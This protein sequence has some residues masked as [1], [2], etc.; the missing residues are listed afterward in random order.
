MRHRGEQSIV[1]GQRDDR[2]AFGGKGARNLGIACQA[3]VGVEVVRCLGI[4]GYGEAITLDRQDRCLLP[5]RDDGRIASHHLGPLAHQEI[6]PMG[7]TRRQF[8]LQAWSGR[9]SPCQRL[10]RRQPGG[11]IGAGRQQGHNRCDPKAM[12]SPPAP[13]EPT[14]RALP[15]KVAG[16]LFDL[17]GTLVDTEHLHYASTL[18]VLRTWNLSLSE[19]DFQPFIGFAE[20][21]YWEALRK[22]FDLPLTATAL[23]DLRTEAYVGLLHATSIDPL[24]GV[25]D[26]LH[27]VRAKGLPMAVASSA[28]R[29]QILASLQA[30]ALEELLPIQRSGHEDVAP[31][32]GKPQPDV[33]LEA[34]GA[35]AVDA[36]AC[37][38]VEDSGVG[39]RAA[40]AAGCFTVCVPC[41]SHP[42]SEAHLADRAVAD[43][44]EI[45]AWLP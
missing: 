27:G 5:P 43:I 28:P 38:A 9:W 33:Y 12:A 4:L 39:M 45:L 37:I 7:I 14:A 15:S 1:A 2:Q 24:P 35:V 13:S 6:M 26:L 25:L 30:A 16:L 10:V 23:A 20:L 17:D 29:P 36:S 44:S 34:A 41:V 21:P 8:Q 3:G 42:T 31:G 11:G 19:E 40:L 22:H 32:K 18:E